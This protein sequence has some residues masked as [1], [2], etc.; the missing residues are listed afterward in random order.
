MKQEPIPKSKILNPWP[1]QKRNINREVIEWDLRTYEVM[2]AEIA[3]MAK[4]IDEMAALSAVDIQGNIYAIPHKSDFKPRQEGDQPEY[5]TSHAI[6]AES[7]PTASKAE[8]IRRYRATMLASTEYREMVR[9]VNAI[10][11][12][13]ERLENSTIADHRLRAKLIRGYY[14]EQEKSL[15][16][17]ANELN[18]C[19]KTAR[20]WRDRTIDE[21]A[22][23]LGF[24]V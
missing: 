23:N 9:R 24:I 12:V 22:K 8:A 13:M 11:R 18:I 20:N 14:F 15:V 21:I 7:D 5:I 16:E 3:A 2:K 19:E 4:E 6:R 10:E 1:R 17:L